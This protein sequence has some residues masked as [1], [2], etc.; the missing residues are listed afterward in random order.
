MRDRGGA[1]IFTKACQWCGKP[2]RTS[3][4]HS[5]FCAVKCRVAYHRFMGMEKTPFWETLSSE[6]GNRKQMTFI[7]NGEKVTL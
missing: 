3:R 6:V 4:G 1:L 5:K 2:Y 7:L